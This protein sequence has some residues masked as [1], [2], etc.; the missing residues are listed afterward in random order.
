MKLNKIG[1]AALT[2]VFAAAALTS[3]ASAYIAIP[4][5]KASL[6]D[7]SSTNW[8]MAISS[9]YDI[10][11][12]SVYQIQV[13]A[14]VTNEE[15]Y[16]ADKAAGFYSD[17]ET[18][19]SDFAGQIAFGGSEWLS[20]GFTGLDEKSGDSAN[21]GITPMG[22]ATYLFYADFGSDGI[23]NTAARSAVNFGEWGNSSPD[24]QLQVLSYTLIDT[25][26]TAILAYDGSGNVT[27]TPPTIVTT[28]ETTTA[29]E[30]T[31]TTTTTAETTTT[32]TT[33]TAETTTTTAETTTTTE[34]TTTTPEETTTTTEETTLAETGDEA[35]EET[36]AEETTTT[37][38]T[39]TTSQTTTAE[40]TTSEETT[41]T[42]AATTAAN[43]EQAVGSTGS[44][45]FSQRNSQLM[46]FLIIAGVVI[47]AAIVGFIIIAVK[48]KR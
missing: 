9:S 14:K 1:A 25:D 7:A 12:T 31:T 5:E 20:F 17:G 6:L 24:Y 38:A 26:G 3:T 46:V 2:A 19:F 40:I 8:G 21:A 22:D 48:R 28:V 16:L 42:T 30:E 18:A 15:Q 10:D 23:N 47:L 39:T 11:Y 34:E 29:P 36:E 35:A 13:V 33:T 43:V 44:V 32:T 41:T 45:D 37:A 4:A 27:V